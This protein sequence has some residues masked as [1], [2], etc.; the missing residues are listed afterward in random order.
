MKGDLK[1]EEIRASIEGERD[2]YRLQRTIVF[3][4]PFTSLK[5]TILLFEKQ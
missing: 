2:R 1:G 4:L 5:R 3:T